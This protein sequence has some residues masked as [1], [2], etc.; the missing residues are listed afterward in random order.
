MTRP[1]GTT[2]SISL[3]DLRECFEGG[4]PAVIATASGD[5]KP[6]VTYLSCVRLVDHERVALSNQFFSKTV[7]NLSENPRASVLVVAPG[8]YDEYRLTLVFERTDRRGP[9]FE[10]LKEDVEV[11][12]ALQGMQGVFK[13]RAADI[14]R[15]THVEQVPGTGGSRGATRDGLAR[16]RPG[17]ESL[18]VLV[19]RMGRS[20]DLDTLVDVVLGGLDEVLGY[21][22]SLL[23]L[24]DETGRRLYTLASHGYDTEGV[25]SEVALGEGILGMVAERCAAIRVGGLHQMDK[26]SRTVR[27]SFESDGSI[28]SGTEI[29]LP[30]LA[31]A[32]SRLVVPAMAL[33]E[34]VGVLMV[35]SPLPVAFDD[36]DEA[37]LTTIA[38]MLAAGIVA[39]RTTPRTTPGPSPRPERVAGSPSGVATHVRHFTVDGSTFMDGDYLIKGVA[40]RILWSLLS[41]YTRDARVDYTNREVRLD[42]SLELPEFRDNFESR[43]I[44]LK[45]R[46]DEHGAPIRIEKTGRGRFRLQ[47]HTGLLLEEVRNR[48]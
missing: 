48:A 38:A 17:V 16:A 5:G 24:L 46:L 40:G 36:T 31:G 4:V 28:A 42:P 37:V 19:A 39:S 21:E 11:T 12:A 15:V 29:P 14:Y 3:E 43:L 6:N 27:R 22:P 30:G 7:R 2:G 33:G 44:L 8:T 35:E 13:L 25:G 26:Y 9:V 1:A 45:R 32:R 23:M 18:S 41:E 34:L 47:V 20:R 10:R